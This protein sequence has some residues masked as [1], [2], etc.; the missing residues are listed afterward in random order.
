MRRAGCPVRPRVRRPARHPLL[1][2]RP[3]LPYLLRPRPDGPAAPPR[4]VP[5]A[6]PADRRREHRD[7]RAH[8]DARRDRRRRQGARHRRPRPDHRED[9]HVLRRR[10]RPRVRRLRQRLLPV[11]ERHE[12]QRD[13]RVAGAPAWRLLRQPVLHPDP[14]H[15][16]PA[17]R[18]PPVEADA[19]ERVA[20]QRRPDLGPEG[21]GRRP[22]AEQ[23]PRGRARLLPGAHLPVLRQPR[24]PRH[25]LARREERVRRGQGRGP[26][27][28]G[29]VPGLRRRDQPH[30]QEGRRG[31]VRQPLR[32]V[33][34]DHRGEP[35]RGADAD[36]PRRAL[37][38]GRPV[39][40]LRPAD[41][42][43]GPVRGRRGQLLRPRCQSPGRERAHAG[44][45]RRLLR[46]SVDHQ[47]LSRAQPAPRRGERRTPRR[48]G[49]AGRDR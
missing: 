6:V 22:P 33:R 17:H 2:R 11:D 29:R 49:G 26:R 20:A 44:S 42:D 3:G 28:P 35:V 21:Q 12:L 30:G 8:R 7:A 43:P 47:R 27:R 24:A 5:G 48:P 41:H 16:H 36:L 4:R 34:A 19:D 37:H 40:R 25:R 9:R 18:G 15:L 38:D 23:D 13:R 1:R 14:P 39:G 46:A 32:H 31:E 45:G 10:R